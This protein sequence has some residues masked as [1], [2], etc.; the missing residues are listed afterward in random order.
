MGQKMAVASSTSVR[1]SLDPSKTEDNELLCRYLGNGSE[2]AFAELVRRH[3][4]LVY[5]A[6]LRRVGGDR[7]LADDVT[8]S[9]FADLARKAPSLKG[10][11]VLT[12]WLYTSTRYAAAQAVRT[13]QRRRTRETEARTINELHIAPEPGWDQL[14]PI[15]DEA[16][17]ELS[18]LDR[19]AVL[20]RFFENHSLAEIGAKFSLS[21]DAARMRIDRA[22][23]KLRGLLANRGI[24]STSVALAAIFASQSGMSAPSGSVARIVA[25]AFRKPI[26]ITAATLG[27]WKILIGLAIAA[28]AT[29]LVVYGARQLRP[30]AASSIP[31]SQMS[32]AG[33]TATAA[34]GSSSQLAGNSGL[35]QR[36]PS[37]DE[38][39][40][41]KKDREDFYGRMSS[42]PEFRASMIALAK[43]RL[44]LFYG[45]LFK[46][47][48]LPAERLDRFKDLLV[49]LDLIYNDVHDALKIE[50]LNILPPGQS[51]GY[52]RDL[53][54][55][56]LLP[57][58]VDKI[59]ALLTD[60]EYARFV[61]YNEDLGQWM[62]TNAVGRVAESMGAP[63]TDEQANLLVVLL[64]DGKLKSTQTHWFEMYY[65]TGL[66]LP[67]PNTC[68]ISASIIEKTNGILAPAQVDAMRQVQETWGKKWP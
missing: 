21:P 39:D 51:N 14:R 12:G 15:I 7:H 53:D 38:A 27:L 60:Q 64:R 26:A 37:S 18:E 33:Q 44:D 28:I 19:E 66:G 5:F 29:G 34:A 13:E 35:G 52:T 8:Q 16:M 43:S 63:L 42:D 10:R 9:V 36:S 2:E 11:T 31:V 47:L 55:K 61:D 32:R 24:A 23:D 58:V 65:A 20:L 3:V 45:P 49:E 30:P 62:F 54:Y 68:A 48:N 57:P 50:G 6:A 22:L 59:K 1:V 46:N 56:V 67:P 17:D 25:A 40:A 4:N 41:I